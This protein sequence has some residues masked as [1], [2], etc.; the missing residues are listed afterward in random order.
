MYHVCIHW[1]PEYVYIGYRGLR[2]TDTQST[3][4]YYVC[5]SF[6]NIMHVPL[7][8]L[9]HLYSPMC[10]LNIFCFCIWIAAGLSREDSRAFFKCNS[11]KGRLWYG[12]DCKEL[13]TFNYSAVKCLICHLTFIKMHTGWMCSNSHPQ[14][15]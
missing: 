12:N 5:C 10:A 13:E 9:Q 3:L 15:A 6:C 4:A 2:H 7:S 14:M 11:S 1:Q 8:Y